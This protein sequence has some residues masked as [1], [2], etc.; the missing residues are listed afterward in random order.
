MDRNVKTIGV[1][2]GAEQPVARG[3]ENR[4][5]TGNPLWAIPLKELSNTRE[6]PI[7]SQSRRPPPAEVAAAPYVPPPVA[8]APA[9]PAH[10]QLSLV[11]TIVGE[12]EAFGI[13]LDESSKAIVRLK[14]GDR[15][16]GWV[17][18]QILLREV[19]FQK[20]GVISTL[21]LPAAGNTV[22]VPS[23]QVADD[24]PPRRARR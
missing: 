14:L 16:G 17:L 24:P 8:P 15:H 10:P 3:P 4:A 5:P 21:T 19:I 13:F 23:T 9:E 22:L 7:F 2:S 20:D 18:R 12:D 1:G 6:R 11:G